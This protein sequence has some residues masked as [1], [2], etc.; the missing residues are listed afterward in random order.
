[1]NGVVV[2]GTMWKRSAVKCGLCFL[3]VKLKN[4][5]CYVFYFVTTVGLEET[6]YLH[7]LSALILSAMVLI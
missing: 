2:A 5:E 1:M 7:T 4:T 6:V 3:E